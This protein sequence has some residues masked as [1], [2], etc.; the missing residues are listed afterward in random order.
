[1]KKV[2]AKIVDNYIC[3]GNCEASSIGKDKNGKIVPSNN[4]VTLENGYGILYYDIKQVYS[5]ELNKSLVELSC[6]CKICGSCNSYLLDLDENKRYSI[7]G[8]LEEIKEDEYKDGE[9]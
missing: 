5:Q 2:S 1:M 9:L 4:F 3:C 7:S 6:T 8:K